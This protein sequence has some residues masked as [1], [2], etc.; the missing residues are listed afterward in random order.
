MN[1]PAD[2]NGKRVA[3]VESH[4]QLPPTMLL[5]AILCAAHTRLRRPHA[6]VRRGALLALGLGLGVA[7][8]CRTVRSQEAA[9]PSDSV[10][11]AAR[12][13]ERGE[14]WFRAACL[15]CHA[16]GAVSNP[17]FRLK[18]GGRSAHDL[19]DLISR[20][21]PDG[22]PGSLSRGAY[23]AITAYLMKLNGMPA[24]PAPLTADSTALG[25][26]RLAFPSTPR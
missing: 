19:F 2:S 12:Q 6:P 1:G 13:A 24:A 5:D 14:Q 18:W 11:L 8:P 16:I 3:C 20:T 7:T 10:A 15:E 25:A 22:S 17:D 4:A 21:M 23:L 9:A 26:L